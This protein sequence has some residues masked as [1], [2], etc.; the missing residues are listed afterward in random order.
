MFARFSRAAAAVFAVAICA[1]TAQSARAAP[2]MFVG[3]SD[4][5][6]KIEGDP[7]SYAEDLGLGAVRVT[8]RWHDAATT[9][10]PTDV[11]DLD[12]AVATG[13]RVVVSVYGPW[14]EAPQTDEERDSYCGYVRDM[15]EREPQIRDVVIW[16]EPNLSIFWRSQ[17]DGGGVP[18]SPAAYEALL[19]RCWDVLHAARPGVNVIAPALC[20]WG[21]DSPTGPLTISNSPVV[22]IRELGAA[23]RAS[24]RTQPIFD[25]VGHHIYGES[26]G[27]RPWRTH[28]YSKR[29]AE[30]DLDK[31]ITGLQQAFAG[32]P[33]PVPGRP[34]GARTAD[35]WYLE[36]GYETAPD[37]EKVWLYTGR[38]TT[39]GVLPDA[40]PDPPWTALPPATSPAPDQATQLRDAVRLAY[41]QP[42]VGAFFNFLLRDQDDLSVWQSGLL[43]ADR[44]PK[45]SYAAFRDVIRE[46]T[47]KAVD[48]SRYPSTSLPPDPAASPPAATPPP[49]PAAAS[50]SHPPLAGD[51]PAKTRFQVRWVR[52]PKRSYRPRRIVR[53]AVRANRQA[54]FLATLVRMDGKRTLAV[55]GV[56][57]ARRTSVIRFPQA[58]LPHG[59][60]RAVVHAGGRPRL[61]SRPFAVR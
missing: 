47:A 5:I 2:G 45:D 54:S 24:G 43:W 37:A 23:Y 27:E 29:I 52:V 9:V 34:A 4:D 16:N 40:V 41:C 58:R 31:L 42:Y 12:R 11:A 20:P 50:P 22:F 6:F 10:A 51:Q 32:T 13:R 30:G 21:S 25:T 61:R 18:T 53:V 59:V 33:Q 39:S 19:A 38:E 35:V 1:A 57:R 17:F 46:V 7:G 49:A 55:R 44:T 48:C 56:L 28:P 26:P 36:A 14:Q 3:V 60:Y 15:L 8:L